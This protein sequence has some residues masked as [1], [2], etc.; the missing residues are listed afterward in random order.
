MKHSIM[1]LTRGPKT[2]FTE[3]NSS[4][5]VWPRSKLGVLF[6]VYFR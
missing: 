6:E 4:K 2:R 5:N 1:E 3:D